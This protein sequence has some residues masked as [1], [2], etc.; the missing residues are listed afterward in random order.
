MNTGWQHSTGWLNRDVAMLH[1]YHEFS[2]SI[3]IGDLDLYVHYLSKLTNYFFAFSHHSEPR[4]DIFYPRVWC[5]LLFHNNLLKLNMKTTKKPF[6]RLPVD[7]PLE[8]T[9]NADAASQRTGIGAIK[10]S[11]SDRQ[12]WAESHYIKWSIMSHL[13]EELNLTKK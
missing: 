2:R 11:I 9:I 6:S 1:P 3:R 7:L 5:L 10:N 4:F 12:R 8:P 13:F